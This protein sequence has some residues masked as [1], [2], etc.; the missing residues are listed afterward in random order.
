MY[1]AEVINV[2]KEKVVEE[3]QGREV[4]YRVEGWMR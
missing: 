2:H 1:L 4:L 3:D